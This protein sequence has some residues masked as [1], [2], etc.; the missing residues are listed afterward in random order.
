VPLL[1]S[2]SAGVQEAAAGAIRNICRGMPSAK[3]QVADSGG[4]SA[5]A[6]LGDRF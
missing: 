2:S 5:L 3:Q 6:K 1:S 4:I